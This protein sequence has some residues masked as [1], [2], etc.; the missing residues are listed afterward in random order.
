MPACTTMPSVAVPASSAIISGVHSSTDAVEP[1]SRMNTRNPAIETTLLTIGA[2]RERTEHATR[3]ERLAD[4][5]VEAVEEDLRQAPVG[6]RGRERLLVGREARRVSCTSH[7]AAIVASS[8]DA[9]QDDRAEGEQ[10][11]DERP[12]AVVVGWPP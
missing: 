2:Q 8:R 3:V 9:E 4:E 10:L 6:E 12:P 7:G 5:R 1:N 11:R